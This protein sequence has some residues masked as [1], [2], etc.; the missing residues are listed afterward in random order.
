MAISE[1]GGVSYSIC[2]KATEDGE[3]SEKFKELC[4]GISPL[5]FLIET[6][7]GYR[8]GAYT[9]LYFGNEVKTSGYRKDEQAFIFSFDTGK[10][11]KIQQPEYAIS[12]TK[13]NFP[14]FGKRDIVIGN[15]ILSG[16][17]SYAMFPIS[18]EKDP[19]APGDYILNGGMKKF[20]IK[21]L[22]I[23]SPFI[24]SNY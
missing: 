19:N 4:G 9:S 12:D 7:D 6:V 13:G 22:E 17:N 14:M 21:E 3:S 15:N 16:A 24:F 1:Q 18:Y 8:F 20:A 5:L 2:Y 10:K 23:L 11:Y